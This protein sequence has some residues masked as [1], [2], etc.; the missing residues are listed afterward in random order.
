[1]RNLRVISMLSVVLL[2][3]V[4]S[5]VFGGEKIRHIRD[6]GIMVLDSGKK[7][8]FAGI[9]LSKEALRML[10]AILAEG[11]IEVEIAKLKPKPDRGEAQPVYLFVKMKEL[12]W[13]VPGNSAVGQR[14]VM[15]NELLLKTGAAWLDPQITDFKEKNKFAEI[16]NQA[17]TEGQGIWSYVED[18]FPS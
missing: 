8:T 4:P 1:M 3:C 15:V 12:D 17:R 16:Q 7:V 9:Q 6:D 13:N 10:P 5:F 11:N 18:R 14:K 2:L